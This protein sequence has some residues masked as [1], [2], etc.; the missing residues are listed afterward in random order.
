MKAIGN[1][2]CLAALAGLMGCVTLPTTSEKH[3]E[4]RPVKPVVVPEQPV[5]RQRPPITPDQV[6]D[7]NASEKADALR[8]ELDREAQRDAYVPP[9]VTAPVSPKAK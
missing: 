3:E 1:C 7:G 9:R 6:T 5:P 8:Q 4:P 2:L